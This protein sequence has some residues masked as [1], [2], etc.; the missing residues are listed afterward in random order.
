[1]ARKLADI[2]EGRVV[3]IVNV[4]CG[5]GEKRL[6]CEMGLAPGRAV[7]VLLKG[8]V[9]VVSVGGSKLCLSREVAEHVIV[10]D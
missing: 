6:L 8:S 3:R 1:M 10:E 4:K 2:E 5:N 7:E 9:V